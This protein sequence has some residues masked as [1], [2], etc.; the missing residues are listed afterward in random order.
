[1]NRS[2]LIIEDINRLSEA[3]HR[4]GYKAPFGGTPHIPLPEALLEVLPAIVEL[5]RE[6]LEAM[7]AK[8]GRR[9]ARILD[10]FVMRM[11]IL[12]VRRADPEIIK[13]SIVGLFL[14]NDVLD[15]RDVLTTVSIVNDC[16][17]RVGIDPREVIARFQAIANAH[18]WSTII[19]GFFSRTPEMKKPETMGY[20][21]IDGPDGIEYVSI[22]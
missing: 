15:Y 21:A 16:A 19:D 18:R 12:A 1:M 9:E 11:A 8:V 13:K 4:G 14:D 7:R 20:K 5:S 3:V 17:S 6:D 10:T 22:R 2:S